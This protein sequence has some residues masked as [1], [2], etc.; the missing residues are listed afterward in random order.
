M[1][2]SVAEEGIT[3]SFV[4]FHLYDCIYIVSGDFKGD[5]V[6]EYFQEVEGKMVK[7]LSTMYDG[8]GLKGKCLGLGP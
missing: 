5:V 4:T 6:W 2:T 7:D 3:I 1:A 8:K